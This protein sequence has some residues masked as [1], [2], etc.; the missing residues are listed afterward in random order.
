MNSIIDSWTNA[1]ENSKRLIKQLEDW[2]HLAH[3]RGEEAY[4]FA[5][6]LKWTALSIF[7]GLM[8][9]IGSRIFLF[10]L[11]SFSDYSSQHRYYF[12]CLPIVLPFCI[13][14]VDR[15]APKMRG[16]LEGTE[17]AIHA[18]NE[19]YGEMDTSAVPINLTNSILT[20]AAGGSVGKEGPCALIGAALASLAARFLK[21]SKD[22]ARTFAIC[23]ISGGFAAVFGL[24]IAGAMFGIEALYVGAIEYSVLFPC[25]VSGIIAH[26]VCFQNPLGMPT[27]LP[28]LHEGA[29]KF[30]GISLVM[31]VIFGLVAI[32]LV[33]MMNLIK[34]LVK[35]LTNHPY[36]L[37]FTGGCVL[38]AIYMIADP[39]Y[40]GLG[41]PTITLA[42]TGGKIFILAFLIKMAVTSVTLGTGGSGGIVTPL[43]FIGATCGS[44]V[45]RWFHIPVEYG[46]LFGLV[47]VLSGATNTPIASMVMAVSM[48]P[49][50]RVESAL[51]VCTAFLISGNRSVI[52]AQR[53]V[54]SKLKPASLHPEATVGSIFAQRKSGWK[55]AG[56][57]SRGPGRPK[58]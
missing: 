21:F 8:A 37:A 57:W 52:G 47:G 42:L 1:K 48:V 55:A 13:L 22:D 14:L 20:V 50:L 10:L 12:L 4:L 31:G 5:L 3:K 36:L 23:G 15:F 18:I 40:A 26:L 43:F 49:G 53:I 2:F 35:P 54:R 16:R 41:I 58:H 44:V 25:V 27:R 19:V 46:A 56:R 28:I 34:Q 32:L 29:L 38:A 33:E 24:P 30:L 9:G 51:V 6:T 17:V 45:A 39:E 7:A 11:Y